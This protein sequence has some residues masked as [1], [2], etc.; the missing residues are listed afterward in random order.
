MHML[1]GSANLSLGVRMQLP[2]LAPQTPCSGAPYLA[3]PPPSQ[4][5]QSGGEIA[6]GWNSSPLIGTNAASV[7]T[8]TLHPTLG[9]RVTK[10]G[11]PSGFCLE[12]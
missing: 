6:L 10:A 1:H 5:T 11:D 8:V 4:R 9:G 12:T 2:F 3:G 7:A